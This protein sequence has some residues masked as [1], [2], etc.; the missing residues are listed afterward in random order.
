MSLDLVQQ[1]R[2]AYPTPFPSQ[3]QH[4]DFLQRTV[5]VHGL[6]LVRKTSGSRLTTFDVSLDVLMNAAG[7]FA[8]DIL[9]DAEG[10]QEAAWPRARARGAAVGRPLRAGRGGAAGAVA[11]SRDAR[12][13]GRSGARDSRAALQVG[14]RDAEVAEGHHRGGDPVGEAP[15]GTS[16][17]I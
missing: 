3:A 14:G 2:A 5:R 11:G 7:S 1:I 6:G 15:R 4:F 16:I 8:V 12:R 13:E 10:A 17:R 9:R